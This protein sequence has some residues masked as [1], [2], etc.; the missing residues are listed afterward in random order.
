MHVC[1]PPPKITKAEIAERRR[2]FIESQIDDSGDDTPVNKEDDLED[3]GPE[4]EEYFEDVGLE[5]EVDFSQGVSLKKEL[6]FSQD[7]SLKKEL[8]F[9]K[10]IG[11]ESKDLDDGVH[12]PQQKF[13]EEDGSLN[14]GNNDDVPDVDSFDDDDLEDY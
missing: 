6:D 12:I 1:G 3:L 13:N 8:D 9:S 14:D 7:V 4:K 5:E 2:K 10:D 11:E